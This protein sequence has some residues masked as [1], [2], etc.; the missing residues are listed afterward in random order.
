MNPSLRD[1]TFCLLNKATFAMFC[2]PSIAIGAMCSLFFF[3]GLNL[4]G[5]E[6]LLS[7]LVI[8]LWVLLSSGTGVF[9]QVSSDEI[10]WNWVLKWSNIET[11]KLWLKN[12]QRDI[13]VHEKYKCLVWSVE[14]WGSDRAWHKITILWM[15]RAFFAEIAYSL[16]QRAM[17]KKPQQKFMLSTVSC[18]F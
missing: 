17:L 13:P 4:A 12:V 15:L 10:V 18:L 6:Y 9:L 8:N 7:F 14:N 5:N 11:C 3:V 2:G 1:A 16:D